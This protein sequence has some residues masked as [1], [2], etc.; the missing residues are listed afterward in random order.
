MKA[1]LLAML[2]LL[3]AACRSAPRPV[4]GA[5]P[6]S[7]HCAPATLGAADTLTLTMSVPHGRELSIQN[8]VGDFFQLVVVDPPASWGPMLMTSTEFRETA[9]VRLPATLRA[10]PFVHGRDTTERVFALSGNYLVR[11]AEVL[12]TDDG[13]PVASCYVQVR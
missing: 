10:R 3:A 2:V 7:M 12:N 9:V 6:G 13:T 8:P 11:M 4:P 5:M 1:C